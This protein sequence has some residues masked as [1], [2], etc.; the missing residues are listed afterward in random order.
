MKIYKNVYVQIIRYLI[1]IY[2]ELLNEILSA[3][4]QLI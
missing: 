3:L 1:L 4:S 2:T